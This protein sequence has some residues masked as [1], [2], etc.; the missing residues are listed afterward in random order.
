[1]KVYV[2]GYLNSNFGDDLLFYILCKRYPQ[3]DFY[4]A[5]DGDYGHRFKGLTNFHCIDAK[6]RNV[7]TNRLKC[8]AEKFLLCVGCPFPWRVRPLREGQFDLYLMLGGSMFMEKGRSRLESLN[9]N[10]RRRTG[11]IRQMI[12]CCRYSA[13]VDANFGPFESCDYF[14]AFHR[15]FSEFDSVSFRETHSYSLFNDLKN[16]TWGP[17]IVFSFI[18]QVEKSQTTTTDPI[19]VVPIDVGRRKGISHL[20][21]VYESTIARYVCSLDLGAPVIIHPFCDA[22]GDTAAAYRIADLIQSEGRDCTVRMYRDVE[23]TIRTICEA[24]LLVGS[25]FHA[26]FLALSVGVPVLPLSY[27]S[28]IVNCFRDI[29]YEGNITSID[30]LDELGNIDGSMIV[31]RDDICLQNA[32]GYTRQFSYLDRVLK[33]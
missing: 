24:R 9:S 21:A 29:G 3:T 5:V 6:K 14:E 17:D 12:G 15:L 18:D 25:R 20:A 1:M 31:T 8:I 16:V 2:D 30:D 4:F 28:K 22:E 33:G 10:I 7:L 19:V 23:D 27:S 26:I 32:A 13:I 11:E